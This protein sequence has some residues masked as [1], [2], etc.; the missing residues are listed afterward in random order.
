MPALDHTTT[1]ERAQETPSAPLSSPPSPHAAVY[2]RLRDNLAWL[3]GGKGYGGLVSLAY[4][5]LAA[6]ALGP[7][8]FGF[9]T[10]IL[11]YGQAIV[12]IAQ[13]QSWQA[14]IRYGAAHLASGDEGRLSR[15]LGL[16]AVAD[17][18]SAIV[19]AALAS[20]AVT[21]VGP[22]LSW[23]DEEQT[24]AVLFAI[25][26][27]FS[28]TA[29]PSGILRLVNRFDLLAYCQATNPS[30]RL[31]GAVAGFA[32][33]GGVDM[34]LVAWAAAAVLQSAST[35]AVAIGHRGKRPALGRDALRR[36]LGENSGIW[37]FM[38]I[39]NLSASVNLLCE[40]IGT[41]AVGAVAGNASA[42]GFRLASRFA[43][44]FAKP[45]EIISGVLFPELA[46]LVASDD[47]VTLR[48]VTHRTNAIA[49]GGAVLVVAL[50]FLSGSTLL[51]RI[52]GEAYQ[53]AYT[54]FVIL[55]LAAAVDLSGFV[56]EP[57]L[58]AHG[59]AVQVLISRVVPGC[60]YVMLLAW[61]LPVAGAIGAA[62]AVLVASV[63]TRLLLGVYCV[64]VLQS[65]PSTDEGRADSLGLNR[66]GK[67]GFISRQSR[68]PLASPRL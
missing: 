24:R 8:Q 56:L 36:A 12:S 7:D 62:S 30:V 41:L 40:E 48:R 44:A 38:I 29:T 21:I 58:I 26:L 32:L 52:A 33:G 14:V 66:L 9:F 34:F 22:L 53:F 10:L 68:M 5:A 4:L 60:F 67:T 49:M 45:V 59:R 27:L 61:L 51:Q 39:T 54:P 6:R 2:T 47:H 1:G 50:A 17:F 13:F 23:T 43:N 55:T 64:R 42:G 25:I 31:I 57:L 37:R 65:L 35:W 16:T 3:L 18:G 28:T 46:R 19:G 63:G 15:L 11:V 20:V